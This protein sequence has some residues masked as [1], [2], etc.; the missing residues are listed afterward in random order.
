MK[1]SYAKARIISLRKII[2]HHRYLYHVLN[3]EEISSHALDS[4]KHELK[5]L[6][7]AYPEFVTPDSPTQRVEGKPLEKFLKVRHRVTQW[8]LEDVFSKEEFSEWEKRLKRLAPEADFDYVGELKIDGLHIVLTYEKG[9]LAS[10]ATRGDGEVG[11]DV[12]QNLK[13]IEA[14]PLEL[15]LPIDCVV[16]GE[17]YMQKHVFDEL[18]DEREKTG[19]AFFANPRNAAAGAIRQLDPSITRSR[20]LDCFIYEFSWPEERIPLTQKEEL[21]FLRTLGF[22]V[23]Q[24]WEYLKNGAKVEAFWEKWENARGKEDYWIDGVVVKVNQRSLQ[25]KLGYTG[26]APRFA[27]AFK[28]SPDLATT[29]IEHVSPSLGR[30]GKIT[31]IAFLKPVIIKGTTVSRASLHNYDEIARLGVREGDTVIVSKAGDVIPKV[32]KVL[33]EL[34]PKGAKEIFPPR[35]CPECRGPLKKEQ[36][37]VD[38]FCVNPACVRLRAK[39]IIHFF[40][41][42][43]LDAKGLGEKIILRLIDQ[44]LVSDVIDV[45]RL[46]ES[47]ISSLERFGEKSAQNFFNTVQ[48]AKKIP[49]WRFFC[50]LGILNVGREG[51]RWIDKWFVEKFGVIRTPEELLRAWANSA[52][53]MFEE[54]P[55]I[56]PKAGGQLHKFIKKK[57]NQTFFK[58]LSGVGMSFV[59]LPRKSTRAL[60]G[61]TFVFT[62]LLEAM[63]RKEAQEKVIALDAEVSENVSKNVDYVVLGKDPGQKRDHAQ[64]LGIP[65]LTQKEF[66][67]LVAKKG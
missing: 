38:Y 39:K 55:G 50:A 3:R 23:N 61:K 35:S 60:A 14:I 63:S 44:G 32:I 28:F 34:R 21:E 65:I 57:S 30:T 19:E 33:T 64:A 1:R 5:T 42:Q 31:P 53:G 24:R 43:G 6:E 17:V 46:K 62:G 48:A 2:N 67:A 10:G 25:E 47:D 49:L 7:D 36:G 56:G 29:I 13:T 9:I 16:E 8:S 12:T 22:K 40:S 59:S 20:R 58:E 4:L 11:E 26:K 45:F 41:K 37:Q 27:L 54:I 18:N 52:E 51:A 15:T 66:L